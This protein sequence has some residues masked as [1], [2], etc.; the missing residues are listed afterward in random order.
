MASFTLVL[1]ER[2][3]PFSDRVLA[4]K[5]G[6]SPAQLRAP[7]SCVAPNRLARFFFFVTAELSP[8]YCAYHEK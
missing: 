7:L 2:S 8:A 6:S 1:H 4:A 5:A 3:F